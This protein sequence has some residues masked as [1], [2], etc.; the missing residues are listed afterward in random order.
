MEH[1][2]PNDGDGDGS[3]WMTLGP[4]NF[5]RTCWT[6]LRLL[7]SFQNS[8]QKQAISRRLLQMVA[9]GGVSQV[10]NACQ[11]EANPPNKVPGDADA[12]RLFVLILARQKR[13]LAW[14]MRRSG[15]ALGF[16][17]CSG[18]VVRAGQ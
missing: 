8:L 13:M 16:S 6:M 1:R 3:E 17:V 5:V 11:K 12:T 9:R 7:H 2:H 14:P 4:S 10:A 18:Y 15:S